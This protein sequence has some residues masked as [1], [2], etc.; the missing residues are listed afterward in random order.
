MAYK[1]DFKDVYAEME[2]AGNSYKVNCNSKSVINAMSVFA[3]SC[4]RI[5]SESETVGNEKTAADA[6]H[7]HSGVYAP[8]SHNHAQSDIT[9]LDN[10]LSGKAPVSHSHAQSDVIGLEDALSGKAAAVHHHDDRYYTETEIDTALAGKAAASHEHDD[11]YYT[12]TEMDSKLGEK[13]NAGHTHD[14]R[15]Y[16]DSNPTNQQDTKQDLNQPIQS[17]GAT[18]EKAVS[19]ASGKA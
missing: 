7:T 1:F 18:A 3:A 13:S 16:T 5:A 10:A 12:E 2:I 14:D 19:M 11:R 8:V 17:E 6:N 15:Y 4:E 9:G